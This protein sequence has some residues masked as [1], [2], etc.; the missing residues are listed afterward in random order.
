MSVNQQFLVRAMIALIGLPLIAYGS[1]INAPSPASCLAA[2]QLFGWDY[3]EHTMTLKSDS[4]SFSDFRYDDSTVFTDGAGPMERDAIAI[5]DRLCVEAFR[6]HDNK[7]A[8]RMRV[9]KRSVIDA[10]GQSD[11]AAWD[12]DSV[13]GTV[14]SLD[15][16]T[17]RIALETAGGAKVWIDAAGAVAFWNLPA[18]GFDPE[19]I[20]PADWGDLVPGEPIYV[21]GDRVADLFRAR[22]IISGGFR[23]FVG[24]VES[25]HPLEEELQLRDFGSGRT[26]S[27]HYDFMEGI[28]IAGRS[29]ESGSRPLTGADIGDIREGD[30][31]LVVARQN[32]EA[33]NLDAMVLITGFSRDGVVQPAPGQSPDWILQAVGIGGPAQVA[34]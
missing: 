19:D 8:A 17:R 13:F 9:T 28:Y 5:D 16:D 10:R 22:V 1:D 21:R 25:M 7:L 33:G 29:A 2:G 3:L 20:V 12:R 14:A 34:Q 27:F 18:R 15:A 26:R 30:P 24:T 6:D 31:V 32:G 11:L 23:T 4:G